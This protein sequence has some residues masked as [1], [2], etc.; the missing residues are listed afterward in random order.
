M[1]KA[2]TARAILGT[3]PIEK[4]GHTPASKSITE[5]D[6]K[7]IMDGYPPK[8]HP[9]WRNNWRPE[10]EAALELIETIIKQ[11]DY[12]TCTAKSSKKVTLE[13]FPLPDE[14]EQSDSRFKFLCR[15][16][17]IDEAGELLIS[18]ENSS[19]SNSD[20]SPID[21]WLLRLHIYLLTRFKDEYDPR[22]DLFDM[23]SAAHRAHIPVAKFFTS[24]V[25]GAFGRAKEVRISGCWHHQS[26]NVYRKVQNWK[27]NEAEWVMNSYDAYLYKYPKGSTPAPV[28]TPIARHAPSR[29]EV[30]H[31]GDD[32]R[33]CC[34]PSHLCWGSPVS[35]SGD[36]ALNQN[37]QYH[38]KLLK[39]YI[40][41]ELESGRWPKSELPLLMQFGIDR[42]AQVFK[43]HLATCDTTVR[44]SASKLAKETPITISP[45][46]S[47][48]APVTPFSPPSSSSSSSKFSGTGGQ[49]KL[50]T[51]DEETDSI[52]GA[53]A[54]L[55]VDDPESIMTRSE[56]EWK[57]FKSVALSG[58]KNV[59]F[60][61]HHAHP[62]VKEKILE[63]QLLKASKADDPAY[64]FE[65][66]DPLAPPVVF[67]SLNVDNKGHPPA[68]TSYPSNYADLAPIP[69]FDVP[70][71][72]FKKESHR[73]FFCGFS[74]PYLTHPVSRL[75]LVADVHMVLVTKGDPHEEWCEE[76]LTELTPAENHPLIR[77]DADGKFS[78]PHRV[79][80]DDQLAEINKTKPGVLTGDHKLILSVA[81]VGDIDTDFTQ[82]VSSAH[83]NQVHM[84]W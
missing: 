13:G 83:L 16:K 80:F 72:H 42:L 59:E 45:S 76:T 36:T 79:K 81:F 52:T 19:P 75:G 68:Y 67:T 12:Q 49:P 64:D 38:F 55:A 77:I 60:M 40:E 3:P 54:S 7:T 27:V 46:G 65:L 70:L 61:Y 20:V 29:C 33:R 51:L 26:L 2:G 69:R 53:M 21:W 30:F 34:R 22:S 37:L 62:D 78:F 43:A 39:N 66:A 71:H 73:W 74:F 56:E 32:H 8:S 18:K 84:P 9:K 48:N 15:H 11:N 24:Q 31:P 50:G 58:H 82:T 5:G 63:H 35:N 25:I 1:N 14:L 10:V 28:H 47:T 44:A 57:I 6:Y 41:G 23:V 17:L 4:K